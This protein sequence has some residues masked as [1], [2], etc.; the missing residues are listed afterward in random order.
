M[1]LTHITHKNYA[2]DLRLSNL[3]RIKSLWGHLP[4]VCPWNSLLRAFPQLVV[5]L[6]LVVN[7]LRPRQI[8]RRFAD[9]TFR[10]ILLNE[11]VRISIEISLQFVPKVPINNIPA[12]V[13]IMA[14]RRPGAKPLSEPM[15]V[16][17][18]THICVARPQ[19]VKTISMGFLGMAH[20]LL[21]TDVTYSDVIMVTMAFQITSVSIVCS[22]VGS[23]ADQRKHQSSA[24]L[25]FVRGI[26]RTKGQ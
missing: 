25:A 5:P 16:N 1:S 26:S 3:G 18:L 20:M 15:M 17:L 13:K 24:S 8:G 11:N 22:T 7:T 9:D 14:G 12:L 2:V 4:A 6:H 10:R 21:A 19:W 23:S